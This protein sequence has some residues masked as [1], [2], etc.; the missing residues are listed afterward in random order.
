MVKRLPEKFQLWFQRGVLF[1]LTLGVSGPVSSSAQI[2][3]G[4]VE[5][6]RFDK[7]FE[8]P[9]LPRAQPRKRVPVPGAPKPSSKKEELTFVLRNV[10][11]DG[12]TVYTPRQLRRV[13]RRYINR[14]VDLKILQFL[15]DALTAKY[16][17]DGYIL[18]QVV[19]PQQKIGGNGVVHLQVIE[20]YVDKVTFQGE[21]RGPKKVLKWFRKR[22]LSSTPLQVKVLERY[23][24]L[25]NDQPGIR[26]RSVLKPSKT[27]PGTAELTI[28]L[29]Y[30]KV[31]AHVG[32]DS[33]G[34]D[35]NGPVTFNAGVSGNSLLR[36]FERFQL[37]GILSSQTEELRY[38]NASV[39]L[40]VT[41]EGTRIFLAGSAASSE[42][43]GGLEVFN[44]NGDSSSFN[45][46][47]THPIWRTRERNLTASL[48]FG[49]INSETT[50]LTVTTAKDRVRYFRAGLTFDFADSA[51]GINVLSARITQGVNIF[52]ARETGSIALSRQFGESAFTRIDGEMLRLQRLFPNWNLLLSTAWQAAFDNLLASQ[53]FAAGG[54]RFS[55]AYD[56]AEIAGDGGMS[57]LAELQYTHYFAKKYLKSLQPYLFFDYSAVFHKRELNR[58]EFFQDLKSIG[59]GIR[60]NFT[61]WLTGY[62]ELAKPLDKIV[63][64]Q[65]DRDPRFFFGFTARY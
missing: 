42:P 1:A 53:E 11:L 19:V 9:V 25:L 31:D 3:P 43:G 29:D 20:G 50:I 14:R 56:S 49:L 58:T 48:G 6:E 57:L 44:I 30:K 2:L 18:S 5:P 27:Q 32:V 22:I 16:R 47:L 37:S 54:S 45:V 35:F 23:L 8:R 55:K 46:Q 59:L 61:A 17:N 28:V 64:S 7:R 62:L 15:A 39:D 4:T 40:P 10:V 33:R 51:G 21:L 63:S 13:Y 26:A 12:V 36:L 60:G 38:F 24:L 52:G 65:G 34:A 41:L